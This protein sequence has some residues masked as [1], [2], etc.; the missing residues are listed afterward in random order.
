MS[1]MLFQKVDNQE[2][3]NQET[4]KLKCEL[5]TLL[6]E[7]KPSNFNLMPVGVDPDVC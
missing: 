7:W 5:D 4:N 6:T 2:M 3:D 1:F